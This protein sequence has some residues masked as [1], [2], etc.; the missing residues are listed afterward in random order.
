[1]DQVQLLMVADLEEV[2]LEDIE[3]HFL[4]EQN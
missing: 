4:A 1:V 2:A 3:L